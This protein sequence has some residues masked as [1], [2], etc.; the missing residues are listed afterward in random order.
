M[1]APRPSLPPPSRAADRALVTRLLAA[2]SDAWTSLQNNLV[3]PLFRANIHGIASQCARVGIGVDAVF[4]QLY[5]NLSRDDFA[6]LRAFRFGCAFS[7][8]IYWHVWNAA[9]GAIR[10]TAGKNDLTLSI[11]A[12]LDALIDQ[13]TSAPVGE[14][15]D[16]IAEANLL[17]AKLW[18]SNPVHA[19]VLVLR[20]DVG[21]SSKEVGC[22]LGKTPANVDQINHRAQARMRTLRDAT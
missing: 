13:K 18:D 9:Q 5:A 6:P 14:I 15:S 10:E 1:T 19:L 11:P 21:L 8:W 22:L 20:Q 17:L 4:S 16:G 12:A 7:S 2:D 3:I